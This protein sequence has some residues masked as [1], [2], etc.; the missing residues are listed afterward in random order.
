[1]SGITG[2]LALEP[3]AEPDE[4]WVRAA[5]QRV[6]HRGPDDEGFYADERIA[7]GARRL[8][9]IDPGPGGHQPLCSSDGRYWMVYDGEIYNYLE[10]AASLLARGVEL[11]TN[12]DAEVLLETY[13]LLGRDVMRRLRGMFA[14]AIWDTWKGQLFCARDPFGLKPLYYAVGEPAI[15]PGTTGG[16]V[17]R[18]A[19]ER[20]ALAGPGELTAVDPDALRRYLSFQY[21]PAPASMTS[22]AWVLPPGHGMIV[23]PGRPVN[24]YRYWRAELRPARGPSVDTPTKILDVMR[25]S[26]AVHLRSDAPV[27]VLLSGGVDSAA[28]SALAAEYQPGLLAFTVGFDLAGYSEIDLAQETAA[29]VGAKSV[30]YV[31]TADE[32]FT[33]LPRIVWHLD[34]PVA[35]AAAVPLW[36]AAR[37]ASRHVKVVLSGDG[38]DELF[39]GYPIY[40]QPS[41]V[42]AVEQ[43]PRWGRAPLQRAAAILPEGV[44]GKGL[45]ERAATP[46]GRRYIG[47]G[48]LFAD[49]EVDALL[50]PGRASP[51]EVTDPVYRQA[52]EAGLDDV[53][54]MQLVDVNTWLAGDILVRADRMAMAHGVELRAP[55]LDREVMA[56]ASRLSREEKT[57]GGTTKFA[58]REAMGEV[59]PQAAAERP[60]LGLAVPLGPWLAGEWFGFA[61]E[62]VRGAQTERWINREAALA[63]L[64]RYHAGEP[65]VSW[66][67]VWAL[68]MFSLWHQIYVERVY[69]P[70]LLGWQTAAR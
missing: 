35:D 11:R 3:G 50:G 45:L 55:F 26:V 53:S 67:Q 60:R 47:H 25:D 32:F 61:D 31:I 56:V 44:K 39:G 15:R 27:G 58:L 4:R 66:R 5:A 8:A 68:M 29:A 36:F 40:H 51:Y 30:P 43:L 28:V 64:R 17:L 18:F 23:R 65:D 20:K 1:M 38:A 34:D 14:F 7:L 46:L 48:Q 22:P 70:V 57:A 13:A 69:D 24:V 16:L 12:S 52:A 2:C 49:D 33:E 21:V 10:L 6:A 19:S 9:V 59:L 41:V 62:L 42:R 54:T 63:L 37:E